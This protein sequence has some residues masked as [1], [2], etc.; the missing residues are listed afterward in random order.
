MD[1]RRHGER[2]ETTSNDGAGKLRG[3][4]R[5]RLETDER[6]DVYVTAQDF[7]A[8]CAVAKAR[9][10]S[11]RALARRILHVGIAAVSKAAAPSSG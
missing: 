10:S 3:R 2:R 4:P 1:E 8:L 11:V 6:L 5:V 7:D 9:G